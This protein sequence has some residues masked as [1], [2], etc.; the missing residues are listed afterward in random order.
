M[1]AVFGLSA[2]PGLGRTERP[3]SSKTCRAARACHRPH[4]ACRIVHFIHHIDTAAVTFVFN[5]SPTDAAMAAW[6]LN[7]WQRLHDAARDALLHVAADARRA[8]RQPSA[9]ARR[10]R[11]P[12][13]AAGRARRGDEGR[14]ALAARPRVRFHA[15]QRRS[16]VRGAPARRSA[17][18]SPATSWGIDTKGWATMFR[19]QEMVKFLQQAME[20]ENLRYFLYP[21]LWDVPAAWNFV[22]TIRHP[23]PNRQHFLRAGSARVV[24]TIRPG[25]EHAFAAFVDQGS[26]GEILPP[27][28]PYLTIERGIP[29]VPTARTIRESGRRMPRGRRIHSSTPLPAPRVARDAGHHRLAGG[30][31]GKGRI[32]RRRRS[33]PR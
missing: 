19:F 29:G 9:E 23:D 12:D 31:R 28:H 24:L 26:C 21:Y 20:W 15:R 6:Q 30:Y 3:R 27:D 8:A 5:F 10:R 17:R 7:V 33:W 2:T 32:R 14:A 25:Y 22:R 11:H 16:A 18:R 1:F 4:R 13:A